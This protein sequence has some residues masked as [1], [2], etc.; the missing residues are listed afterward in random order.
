MTICGE[1]SKAS[2]N[3]IDYAELLESA[4]RRYAQT[5]SEED[6]KQYEDAEQNY[7]LYQ[8][9]QHIINSDHS[10]YYKLLEVTEAT[11]LTEI[12]KNFRRMAFRYHPAKTSVHG[13]NEAMRIIQKAYFEINTEEKRA[14]Y[15]ERR[16]ISFF[17]RGS[18]DRS[19][20]DMRNPFF[21]FGN[22]RFQFSTFSNGQSDF[23]I[24]SDQNEAMESLYRMLYRHTQARREVGA[25]VTV[26]TY[27]VYI[28]V[29]FAIIIMLL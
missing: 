11:P 19:F 10:D 15:N 12:K 6:K 17:R 27:M 23:G 24:F 25:N 4:K 21:G 26:A 3:N 2:S 28:I 7:R 29:F 9:I 8:E 1:P 16:K 14:A 22:T 5:Q 13:S 18:M 20:S